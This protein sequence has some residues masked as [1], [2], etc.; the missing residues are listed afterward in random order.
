LYPNIERTDI[1][2][3]K[4]IRSAKLILDLQCVEVSHTQRD[5]ELKELGMRELTGLGYNVCSKDPATLESAAP[6]PAG[7]KVPSATPEISSGAKAEGTVREAKAR[8]TSARFS[9]TMVQKT[10]ILSVDAKRDTMLNGLNDASANDSGPKARNPTTLRESTKG[11][12]WALDDADTEIDDFDLR[13]SQMKFWMP[14]FIHNMRDP[15]DR[16]DC[17]AWNGLLLA[18]D[19]TRNVTRDELGWFYMASVQ[20]INLLDLSSA[21]FTD[22]ELVSVLW[23]PRVIYFMQHPEASPWLK[24][25]SSYSRLQDPDEIAVR[26]AE[27]EGPAMT[28]AAAASSRQQQ[29]LQAGR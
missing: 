25:L 6:Q 27:A 11:L 28:T 1:K 10:V 2:I 20:D 14:L 16:P 24:L 19:A 22:L 7:P 12:R 21:V 23:A 18:P 4:C 9:F 17:N 13:L 3:G 29:P 8:M 15:E 26:A 5:T